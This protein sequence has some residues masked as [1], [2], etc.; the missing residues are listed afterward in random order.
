MTPE[1]DLQIAVGDEAETALPSQSDLEDWVGAVLAHEGDTRHEL[2][3]RV[4]ERDESQQLNRDYRGKDKPTNVLSFPFESPPGIELP[5]LGDL[6]I[7]HDVVANE[8]Q[9]QHKSIHDH[10]AHL[11]IHGCLH[12]LGYDHI[13]DD[14]AEQME[15]L[16]R[17]LLTQFGIADPYRVVDSKPDA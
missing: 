5:L 9:E 12:L 16:E 15:T 17:V 1:I 2:T 7:C 10:Y 3:I 4:V 14:E 11:V 13:D 8:A 6:V